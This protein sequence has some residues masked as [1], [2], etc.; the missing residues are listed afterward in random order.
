MIEISTV[1]NVGSD[2]AK[3]VD[4]CGYPK[5]F[6]DGPVFYLPGPSPSICGRLRDFFFAV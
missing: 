1:V 5:V 2:A 4:V 3:N 6:R